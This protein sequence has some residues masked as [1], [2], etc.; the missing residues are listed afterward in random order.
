MNNR[1]SPDFKTHRAS[2]FQRDSQQTINSQ[3]SAHNNVEDLL[4]TFI[5]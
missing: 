2:T 4:P 3:R 5:K 1:L